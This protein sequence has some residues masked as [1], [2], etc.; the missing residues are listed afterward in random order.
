M[1]S[2]TRA[3][4]ATIIVPTYNQAAYL[5]EAL[6]SLLQQSDA[7]WEAVVVNDGSTDNTRE[8][9]EAYASK[10]SRIRCI[11]QENGGVAAALNTGLRHARGEWIHW[12][13]SDDLFH[14]EKLQVNRKWIEKYP[15]TSFFFSYFWLLRQATG[16]RE[17]R[18]LWGPL[19][20]AGHQLITLFYRNYISGITICVRRQAWESIGN[21]DPGLRYAQD[22]D[23]WLRLLHRF[24]GRF[25]PEWTVISRNHSEQGSETFPDAC[26]YDTAKAAIRFINGKSF[27]ELVPHVD[28]LDQRQAEAAVKE[29]LNVACEA[30]SFLYS[31]GA[32][33]ALVLRLLEWVF[34]DQCRHEVLRGLV[35]SRIEEM[36]FV[37]GDDDWAW[38]W[39]MLAAAVQDARPDFPFSPVD[40]SALALREWRSKQIL[41]D[42]KE[43]ALRQYL[44]RFEGIDPLEAL[45]KAA[46]KARL[47]FLV[48]ERGLD[49]DKM[50]A[51]AATLAGQGYRP[52]LLQEDQS[53]E[54]SFRYDLNIPRITTPRLDAKTL[55]WLGEV[56]LAVSA[57]DAKEIW[58]NA[59]SQLGL[60]PEESAD[61]VR[62]HVSDKLLPSGRELRP[63]IFLERV[64]WGG[65]AE[66]VVFDLSG[67]LDQT[68]Y[69]P[70][71]LTMFEEHTISPKWPEHVRRINIRRPLTLPPP[72][73]AVSEAAPQ[74]FGGARR[75]LNRLRALYRKVLPETV[76]AQLAAGENLRR[77][78]RSIGRLRRARSILRERLAAKRIRPM[79]IP[80]SVL[81]RATR[82]AD[83]DSV[84]FDFI[85]SMS[86]HNPSAVALAETLPTL[87]R[88]GV[89][90]SVMEEA[91]V[92]AWLAQS[93]LSFPY[94]A[95]LH[96]LE[97]ACL[98]DM[99][100]DRGRYKAEKRLLALACNDAQ[101]VTMPS[102]GCCEDLVKNFAI[103]RGKIRRIWNPINCS[104]IARLSARTMPEVEAW[105]KANTCFRMVIVGRIDPQKNHD[106][107]LRACALLKRRNLSFSLAI[108]GDGWYRS[109]IE[110]LTA[111]LGIA[112]HVTIAGNQVNPF[113]WIAASD[114]LVLSSHFESFA[115]VLA[116]AMACG[117]PVVA[118][119][120]PTGPAEVT[121]NGRYGLLVEPDA[122]AL[123]VGIE[124]LMSDSVLRHTLSKTGRNRAEVFDIKN[125]IPDWEALI[126]QVWATTNG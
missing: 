65:G 17:K 109:A 81:S 91:A 110:Q 67:H 16:E 37:E 44:I 59:L 5:G 15:E 123:A 26:Y 87:G 125:I 2:M 94:I 31:L 90:M 60:D 72:A 51:V 41:S 106:L 42:P 119:N 112:E 43:A 75:I 47:A 126:D 103:D 96:T 85:G 6:D 82:Q 122:E 20:E 77:L 1:T 55:P 54:T 62:Q 12:L 88:N 66:R 92:A 3:P 32:H 39:R 10:D 11:H 24:P 100:P 45:P 79:I 97:S 101:A 73:T 80:P 21:F 108:V 71:V 34:S 9:A 107:L 120:C 40:V 99:Y 69:A 113:P 78:R 68:R 14:P 50:C 74:R 19:P 116:E 63:V 8:V 114:A 95:T 58:V 118:V 76:R 13:S 18:D 98:K 27:A 83:T 57:L 86:H 102:Q 35:K 52:I 25:I 53:G 93:E 48:R 23:Q 70:I 89:V 30:S 84:G 117:T 105:K 56:E 36:S 4:F 28:L 29:T 61:D 115:L 111:D 121:E 124:K 33:P 64:L 49:V 7:D 104:N 38:M 22:Y 46:S